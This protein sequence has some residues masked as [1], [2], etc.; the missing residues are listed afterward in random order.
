MVNRAADVGDTA[1]VF[2]P[3]PIADGPNSVK[4]FIVSSFYHDTISDSVRK[5]P[6]MVSPRPDHGWAGSS[7]Q[8]AK[9][10]QALYQGILVVAFV[11]VT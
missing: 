7:A 3:L 6:G 5:G 11:L 9:D 8:S 2:Q 10:D 1:A 4:V